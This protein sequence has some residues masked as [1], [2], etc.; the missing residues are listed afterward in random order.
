MAK[1]SKKSKKSKSPKPASKVC[2]SLNRHDL[3]D[4]IFIE[5]VTSNGQKERYL[6]PPSVGLAGPGETVAVETP[7]SPGVREVRIINGT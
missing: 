5:V 6:I 3:Y 7:N 1:K 2:L 4:D